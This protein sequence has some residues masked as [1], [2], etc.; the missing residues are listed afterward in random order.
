MNHSI[1]SKCVK[2]STCVVEFFLVR[3]VRFSVAT[4]GCRSSQSAHSCCPRSSAQPNQPAPFLQQCSAPT[5]FPLR[6]SNSACQCFGMFTASLAEEISKREGSMRTSLSDTD[7]GAAGDSRPHTL[8]AHWRKRLRQSLL[9]KQSPNATTA[10]V[11]Y[12]YTTAPN[13]LHHHLLALLQHDNPPPRGVH[14]SEC[15][16][17]RW[18]DRH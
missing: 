18:I 3:P 4:P 11:R 5:P 1:K 17:C 10:A 15:F 13:T 8:L 16:C 12:Q 14:G 6:L 2:R 9:W 7:R